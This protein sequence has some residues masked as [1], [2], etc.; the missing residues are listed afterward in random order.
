MNLIKQLRIA[1]ETHDHFTVYAECLGLHD[2]NKELID[3][4][5]LYLDDVKP[6]SPQLE[7]LDSSCSLGDSPIASPTFQNEIAQMCSL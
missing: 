6:H 2:L 3:I 7:A 4:C 1:G 5:S